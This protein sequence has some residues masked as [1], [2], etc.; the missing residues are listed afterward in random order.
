[1]AAVEPGRTSEVKAKTLLL[2]WREN[3]RKKHV[4]V[5]R[6]KECLDALLQK[7]GIDNQFEH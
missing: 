2:K 6:V 3:Q 5:S 7:L 4:P 1:M